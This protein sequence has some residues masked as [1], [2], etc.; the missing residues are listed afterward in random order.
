VLELVQRARRRFRNN[1]FLSQGSLALSIALALL[2]VLLLTGVEVLN[3]YWPVA[4]LAAAAAFCLYRAY[5]RVPSAYRI[6]QVIDRRLS[7]FDTLSTAIHFNDSAH[8]ASADLRTSQLEQA[9]RIAATVDPA[10]A[11][12]YRLP[13]S[14][15]A[16]A[17]L[18]LVSA[19]LIGVRY[20]AGRSLDLRPPLAQLLSS[21]FNPGGKKEVAQNNTPRNLPQNQASKD[22]DTPAGDQEEKGA[23]PQDGQSSE[24]S[25]AGN[26]S[27]AEKNGASQDG[28]DKRA[29]QNQGADSGDENQPQAEN[30]QD[31]AEK[32]PSGA[33]GENKPDPN[34]KQSDGKQSAENSSD[35]SS[36]MSKMKDAFQNLFSR[37]KPQNNANSQPQS[38]QNQGAKQ[39][40]PNQSKQ[41]SKDGQQ[42]GAQPA[43][44]ENGQPD[45][46]PD[47]NDSQGKGQGKNDAQQANKQPGSGVGSQDGSKQIHDAEMLAAMGKISELI[48]KRSAALTGES[49]VEVQNTSQQLHTA[50]V[51][52]G[53]EH[54]Q[55]G[56]EIN[57][58]EIPV[59][60][61]P[62]V[63]QYFN[64]LRK[65]AQPAPKKKQ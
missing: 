58:D 21:T 2:I 19:T 65:T 26:D 50:Y 13:H 15:Y 48:G 54:A 49:T 1:E 16:F 52:R 39:G 40:Q 30:Q 61:Q 11:V 28:Q 20:G 32:S 25:E 64:Q 31:S 18:F 37:P 47:Q 63:E 7:L 29:A 59:A 36:L 9:D 22:E 55:S 14:A 44:G 41:N 10:Q 60:L 23:K 62:Y 57:R 46:S 35:S 8:Q 4:L 34:A 3:W 53:A 42:S 24:A 12:P 45:N 27:S 56:A 5:S 51:Q 17:A 6:A 43:D 38:A 33:D